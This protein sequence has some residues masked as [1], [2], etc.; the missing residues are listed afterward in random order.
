MSSD[1]TTNSGGPCANNLCG[2]SPL[3]LATGPPPSTFD[4]V[5]HLTGGPTGPSGKSEVV[6]RLSPPPVIVL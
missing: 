2:E 6:R 4:V 3:S 5:A 1:V